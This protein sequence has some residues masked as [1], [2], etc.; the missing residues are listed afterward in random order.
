MSA[1]S[2]NLAKAAVDRAVEYLRCCEIRV[3]AFTLTTEWEQRVGGSHVTTQGR[4]VQLNMGRYPG[5]FIRDWFAMHE[6]GHVLWACHRPDRSK[7]FRRAF[8]EPFPDD[9]DQVHLQESW[10]TP[11]SW[12]LSWLPGP[13]RPEGEPSWYGARAGGEE[14][15]CEL[16][17]LMYAHGDF[18]TPPPPDLSELWGICW[19]H[20][21][22]T[23]T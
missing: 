13:H 17:G 14:R 5:G 23:M 2:K 9:Y 11:L 15:F 12:K 19:K 7:V 21:L 1:R 4:A 20:G 18:S 16:I 10:K 3:P 8:G 6:L 22:S